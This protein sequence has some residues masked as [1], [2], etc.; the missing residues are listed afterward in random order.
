MLKVFIFN[1]KK[2]FNVKINVEESKCEFVC[3]LEGKEIKANYQE[4]KE[5]R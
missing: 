4:G 5:E 3:N 1:L 2:N